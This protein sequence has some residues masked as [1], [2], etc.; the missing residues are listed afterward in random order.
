M[1]LDSIGSNLMTSIV[2]CAST[3]NEFAAYAYGFYGNPSYETNCLNCIELYYSSKHSC[4]CVD[5]KSNCYFFDGIS[6][7][8]KIFTTYTPSL[9][10]SV[11]FDT[12]CFAMVFLF[13]VLTSFSICCPYGFRK[14]APTFRNELNHNDRAESV[15]NPIR[16]TVPSGSV[17]GLGIYFVNN[18]LAR[19]RST[20]RNDNSNHDVKDG[21]NVNQYDIERAENGPRKLSFS[22]R[23]S[24]S[25]AAFSNADGAAKS[26]PVNKEY[27]LEFCP[28]KLLRKCLPCSR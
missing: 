19:P 8:N 15:R 4:Y 1:I 10:V 11:T 14:K 25:F 24:A 2:T 13:S 26:K 20:A 22:Q 18:S 6:D 27:Y 28:R 17:K 3:S 16:E 21:Q 9:A 12:L 5:E 23:I 7:C